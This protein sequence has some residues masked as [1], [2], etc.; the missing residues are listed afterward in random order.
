MSDKTEEPTPKRIRKAQEEGNSPLSTFASQ[1]VAFLCAIAIAPAAAA[2][3]AARS[4][5]DLRAAIGQA[6]ALTPS[7][8]LDTMSLAGGVLM[9]SAPILGVAAVTGAVTSLV[10]TG[11]VIATKKLAPDL[12]KLNPVEGFK[13]LFSSQRLV[14]VA[15]AALLALA[16]GYFA[17]TALRAHAASIA[18]TVGRVDS[19]I[20][21]AREIAMDVAKRA[22]V[23]GLFLAVLDVVVTRRAWR[24]RLMMSKDE[25]KR[26]H[27]ESEG[28]PEQKAARE[29]AHHEMLASATV[30]N[31]KNASVVVVNPT[32]LACALKYD[33]NE[34]DAPVVV[35]TGHGDLARRIVEAAH[36]YG[37]P[38]LRDVP[39]ARALVELQPGDEIPEALYEAV[40]EILREAW[41]ERP[42]T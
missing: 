7:A 37:V 33:G 2:A 36:H 31:V 5:D 12:G 40:A 10:Q 6:A 13:Q 42:P 39:L 34:D 4:G 3:L 9:M 28:D 26:E 38:V 23:A 16:V 20:V 1:S 24:K 17:Y 35:A 19:A 18:H 14:N 11:G 15:R 41:D 32:H 29:R 22:A 21:V 30:G 8:H 27:K 25:V